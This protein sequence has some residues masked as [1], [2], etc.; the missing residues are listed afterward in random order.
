MSNRNLKTICWLHLGVY[1]R[2]ITTEIAD[3]SCTLLHPRQLC[4]ISYYFM[5]LDWHFN[6]YLYFCFT[7]PY[8]V[9]PLFSYIR[10]INILY[11]LLIY[12]KCFKLRYIICIYVYIYIYIYVCMY[13][14]IHK[15]HTY[16]FSTYIIYDNEN[17]D[18]C[19]E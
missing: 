9:S 16:T 2:F 1:P 18:L 5:A 4:P 8:N 13:V 6:F 12:L 7:L 10:K 11:K 19:N 17:R 3:S 14:C 15:S